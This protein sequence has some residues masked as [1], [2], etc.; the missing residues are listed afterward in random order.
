MTKGQELRAKGRSSCDTEIMSLADPKSVKVNMTTGTGVDIEWKDGHTS[1]YSF[2]WLR[3]A[4]PC[5]TCEEAR[6]NDHRKAGEP[7][8]QAASLL[9]LYK[10]KLRPESANPVG[11]Y[12]IHFKWN[13]G[14]ESGIYS[15]DYLR[16]HC[17]CSECHTPVATDRIQ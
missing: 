12:A 2:Q 9:P 3:D 6:K 8:K 11:K 5:A 7:V 17:Q 16:E 10:P 15:W 4:C 13:D 1:H 14:H